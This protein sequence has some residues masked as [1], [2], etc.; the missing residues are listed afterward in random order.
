M[1]RATYL[2]IIGDARMNSFMNA[3]DLFEVGKV[4]GEIEEVLVDYKEGTDLTLDRAALPIQE[5]AN[6]DEK[7]YIIS[8]FHLV[9]IQQDNVITNNDGRI[10][11][12]VNKAVR[13]ISTG[14]KWFLL[15]EFVRRLGF[16]VETDEHRFIKNVS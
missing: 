9:S 3:A 12:F 11:P 5:I 8:L 4:L 10:K 7:K 6:A 15:D 1:T 13:I 16:T 2:L 14:E